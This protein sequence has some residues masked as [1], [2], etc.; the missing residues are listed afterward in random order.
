M[1]KEGINTMNATM[2][3]LYNISQL[4][5]GEL[6]MNQAKLEVEMGKLIAADTDYESVVFHTAIMNTNKDILEGMAD[7]TYTELRAISPDPLGMYLF[8]WMDWSIDIIG[9]SMTDHH[10][11]LA[12]KINRYVQWANRPFDCCGAPSSLRGRPITPKQM[13]CIMRNL[14]VKDLTDDQIN[15]IKNGLF[16]NDSFWA[17]SA[18]HK[19]INHTNNKEEGIQS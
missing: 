9:V 7:G 17:S 6:K 15:T 1:S 14:E 11:I 4:F 16:T 13:R 10:T 19:L 3:F 5:I 2:L 18:I 8:S 12:G